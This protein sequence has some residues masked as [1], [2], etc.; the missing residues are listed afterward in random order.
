M[1]RAWGYGGW[2]AILG[3]LLIPACA[4]SQGAATRTALKFRAFHDPAEALSFTWNQPDGWIEM[5]GRQSDG[6]AAPPGEGS[7]LYFRL[8]P[9]WRAEPVTGALGRSSEQVEEETYDRL[10]LDWNGDKQFTDAEGIKG[11]STRNGMI[12]GPVLDRAASNGKGRPVYNLLWYSA[13]MRSLQIM[14]A[15]CREGSVT[16]N[17]RKR[18]IAVVDANLDG[19]YR[20]NSSADEDYTGDVL[21]LDLNGDGR[22]TEAMPWDVEEAWRSEVFPMA[23]CVQMPDERLYRLKV[24]SD[25]SALSLSPDTSP[26]GRVTSS[27]ARF[28]MELTGDAGPVRVRAAHGAASIPAGRYRL[29][30]VVVDQRDK[31]GQYWR[32]PIIFYG[33]EVKPLRVAAGKTTRLRSGPPLRLALEITK[34]RGAYNFSLSL[35]D[36]TGSD[37]SDVTK[38]D[39]QRPAEPILRITNAR[40]KVVHVEKFHY[41]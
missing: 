35:K 25:G 17:G 39:G 31:T 37:V 10:W 13:G 12:F 20:Y 8:R 28:A 24:M 11:V 23:R 18:K 3:S 15:G 21:L 2:A 1:R 16:L 14:P 36:R 32:V 7:T 30:W 9:P 34:N 38:P 27:C 41:G 5:R 22:Y 29:R 19:A 4:G 26:R 40:G 6:C 33:G